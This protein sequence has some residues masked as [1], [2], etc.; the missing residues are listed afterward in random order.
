MNRRFR[1]VLA[2]CLT[3]WAAIASAAL[4]PWV[5]G[6]LV[7]DT[8]RDITWVADA[9]LCLTL[10]NCVNGD[11]AGGML[12]NDANQWAADLNYLGYRD[13]RLPTALDLAGSEPC[14]GFNCSS[15]EMGHLF[16]DE[17]GGVAWLPSYVGPPD[18]PITG[19]Q[20]PFTNIQSSRYWYETGYAPGVTGTVAGWYFSFDIGFQ[21]YEAFGGTDDNLAAWAV[22]D[23]RPYGLPEPS[24]LALLA[25]GLAGLA[26]IRQRKQ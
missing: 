12:W 2:V 25:V 22:R 20:G 7:Y 13:W 8:N 3:L 18:N 6:K 24:S 16:Y 9:N 4:V 10:G 21:G 5:G 26:T 15:S 17:L 14:L 1:D 11:V 23:G 19:N